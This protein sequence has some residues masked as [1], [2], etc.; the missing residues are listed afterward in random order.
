MVY[1]IGIGP[2]DGQIATGGPAAASPL[3]AATLP[4]SITIGGQPAD[5]LYLGLTPTYVG[6]AQANVKVPDLP[7]GDYALVVTVNGVASN[8]LLVSIRRP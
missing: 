7:T 3:P 8:S 6:L 2:V 4:Y 5:S 1:L